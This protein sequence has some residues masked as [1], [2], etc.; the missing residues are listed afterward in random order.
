MTVVFQCS[1]WSVVRPFDLLSWTKSASERVTGSAWVTMVIYLTPGPT[2][3]HEMLTGRFKTFSCYLTTRIFLGC[4]H[5]GTRSTGRSIE[6]CSSWTARW[7]RTRCCDTTLSRRGSREA[8][9]G[10]G[11][12]KQKHL[13]TR[14]PTRRRQGWTPMK[15]TARCSAPSAPQRWPCSI[16]RRCTTSSTSWPATAEM[17]R[18]S[19]EQEVVLRRTEPCFLLEISTS[20]TMMNQLRSFQGRFPVWG[21]LRVSAARH[22]SLKPFKYLEKHGSRTLRSALVVYKYLSDFFFLLNI[23]MIDTVL[24]F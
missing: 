6:P 17:D 24:F 19:S 18:A 14:L 8:G 11:A 7:R 16:R 9:R 20:L 23:F 3:T 21:K 4:V 1:D 5:S 15:F 10:G 2:A 12:R 22:P 13:Q